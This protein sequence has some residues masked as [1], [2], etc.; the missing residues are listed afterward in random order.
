ML[1]AAAEHHRLRTLDMFQQP[2]DLGLGN[3]SLVG[4]DERD[5]PRFGH[6]HGKS[7]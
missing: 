7:D 2:L 6:G 4:L 5:H 1:K 3:A